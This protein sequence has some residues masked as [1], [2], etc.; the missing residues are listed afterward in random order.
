MSEEKQR[1]IAFEG[2]GKKRRA[3]R[4]KIDL[5]E[6]EF[7]KNPKGHYQVWRANLQL[8]RNFKVILYL[9][10]V[11]D[12]KV[13]YRLSTKHAATPS[14]ELVMTARNNNNKKKKI[15]FKTSST[16]STFRMRMG[17]NDQSDGKRHQLGLSSS[18]CRLWPQKPFRK[19]WEDG[20]ANLYANYLLDPSC[21]LESWTDF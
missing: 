3:S 11:N 5:F 9:H 1:V 18:Y 12:H 21:P 20:I 10:C 4:R 15:Q 14:A 8:T 16:H 13:C 17:H 6:E 2:T 7:Q 19:A